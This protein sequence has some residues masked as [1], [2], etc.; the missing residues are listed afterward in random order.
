MTTQTYLAIALVALAMDA[1]LCYAARRRLR[2]IPS[3]FMAA[4]W[5]V[6]LP[7]AVV[8]TAAA[9]REFPDWPNIAQRLKK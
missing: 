5:P 1:A 8:V 4:L 9:T 2:L 7:I 3:M 6:A